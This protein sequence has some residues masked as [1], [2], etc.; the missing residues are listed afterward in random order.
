MSKKI[1]QLTKVIYH[2]NTKNDENNINIEIME[3]NHESEIDEILRDASN[4]INKFKSQLE[5][6]KSQANLQLQI[7]KLKKQNQILNNEINQ[8]NQINNFNSLDDFI[9]KDNF[10]NNNKDNKDN[11]NN[12]DNLFQISNLT[13]DFKHNNMIHSFGSNVIQNTKI[14]QN[15]KLN[16]FTGNNNLK[17]NKKEILNENP[18]NIVII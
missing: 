12:L 13:D 17:K 10:F 15:N 7:K 14:S 18:K 16:I 6:R 8:K 5:K 2:L 4:K 11:I 3:K 1:A 9:Q